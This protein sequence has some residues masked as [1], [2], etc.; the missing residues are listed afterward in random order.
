MVNSQVSDA[1]SAWSSAAD[2]STR[3]CAYRHEDTAAMRATESEPGQA[4]D[5][6]TI[7]GNSGYS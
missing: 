6:E 1:F 5:Y 7:S 2:N 3:E 4:P